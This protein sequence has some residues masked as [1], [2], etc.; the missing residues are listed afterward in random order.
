M[1][2]RDQEYVNEKELSKYASIPLPTLRNWRFRG[3]GPPYKKLSRRMIRYSL[4]EV[5]KWMENH[6]VLPLE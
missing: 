6:T 4:K 2:N 3:Q 1:E 5:Q